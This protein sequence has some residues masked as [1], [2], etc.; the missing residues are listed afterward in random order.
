LQILVLTYDPRK[1][2]YINVPA[3]F[4]NPDITRGKKYRPIGGYSSET[5]SHSIT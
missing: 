2:N 1:K 5:W 3:Y 4:E